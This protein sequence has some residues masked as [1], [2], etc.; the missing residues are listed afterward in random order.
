MK[1]FILIF[2]FATA[3]TLTAISQISQDRAVFLDQTKAVKAKIEWNRE[4][5]AKSAGSIAIKITVKEGGKFSVLLLTDEDYQVAIGKRPEPINF[6]PKPI[7]NV[8]ASNSFEKSI[9]L[10]KGTYWL[11]IENQEDVEKNIS[12]TCSEIR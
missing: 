1:K 5:V 4:I 10:E 12:L 2:S 8:D 7:I 6:R 9:A 11:I 3:L